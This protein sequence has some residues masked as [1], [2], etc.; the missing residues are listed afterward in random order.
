[1]NWYK[2]SQYECYLYKYSWDWG[3]FL[4]PIM[5]PLIPML[6]YLGISPQEANKIAEKHNN[7]PVVIKQQLQTMISEKKIPLVQRSLPYA[8]NKI[9]EIPGAKEEIPV[10]KTNI[11]QNYKPFAENLIPYEGKSLRVYNDGIGKPTIGIGH[12]II[13][14]SRSIFNKVLG[15]SNQEYNDIIDKKK[16][17]TEDQMYKLFY[18]YDLDKHINRAKDSLPNFGS[19]PQYVQIA[20]VNAVYRGDLF[21]KGNRK[22]IT[23][24]INSGNWAAAAKAYINHPQYNSLKK[25]LRG[26]K[27]RM[28]TNQKSMLQYAKELGQL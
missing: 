7:N 22:K 4:L 19:Y 14:E 5:I 25:G 12:L 27:P 13:P 28:N 6:V 15:I 2:Q 18:E 9:K 3:K 11:S 21:P 17:L 24:L 16:K 8:E 20:L 1:M 10:E 26:I 23:D